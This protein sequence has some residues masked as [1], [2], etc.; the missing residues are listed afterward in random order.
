M[1]LLES[2]SKHYRRESRQGFG[3][4]ILGGILLIAAFIIFKSAYPQT[5]QRGLFMPFLAG[6]LVFGIGGSVHGFK[7]RKSMAKGISLYR[8]D[9]RSFLNMETINVERTHRSWRRVFGIWTAVALVGTV[10]VFGAKKKN[11][12]GVAFG[13]LIVSLAGFLEETNSRSF[14][15]KYYQLMTD[16]YAKLTN[17]EV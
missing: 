7:V 12:T 10:L 8:M 1:D 17:L 14:N 3:A 6:G 4:A 9:K 5:V 16:E 11:M 13:T 2:Y 15:E